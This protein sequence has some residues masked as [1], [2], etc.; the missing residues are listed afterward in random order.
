MQLEQVRRRISDSAIVSVLEDIVAMHAVS[1][2]DCDVMLIEGLVPDRSEP[3]TAKLNAAIVKSLNSEVLLVS[4]G[5]NRTLAQ[6]RSELRLQISI[7]GGEQ[8][9][10]LGCL[11]NKAGNTLYSTGLPSAEIFEE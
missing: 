1:S 9:N 6:V 11:I 3:Y 5:C 7:Y 2:G 10:I 4:N 8:A